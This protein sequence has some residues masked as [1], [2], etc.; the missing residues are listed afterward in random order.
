VSEA[1]VQGV[2]GDEALALVMAA[3]ARREPLPEELL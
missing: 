1:A 2:M 3:T